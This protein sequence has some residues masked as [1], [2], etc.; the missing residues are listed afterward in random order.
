MT[1]PSGNAETTFSPPLTATEKQLIN[2]AMKLL[3]ERLFQRE[4]W[5][6]DPGQVPDYMRLKLA[7]EPNELFSILLLDRANKIIGYETLFTGFVSQAS[8]Y[9]RVIVQR[10]LTRNAC[11]VI[12]VYN[13]PSGFTMPSQTDKVLTR[14]VQEVLALIEV[15]VLDHFIVGKGEPFS[16]AEAGLL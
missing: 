1:Q 15:T 9:S 6:T 16:F 11:A 13:H 12:L 10:A 2:Q 7:G 14:R 4:G 3:E 8:V 5:I